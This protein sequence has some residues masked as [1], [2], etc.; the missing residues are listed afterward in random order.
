MSAPCVR[1]VARYRWESL[2]AEVLVA[3]L[4]SAA[5]V[6]ASAQTTVRMAKGAHPTF[7]LVTIKLSDPESHQQG[8][9]FHGRE[10]TATG[11]TVQNLMMFAY[12]VHGS[13]IA[14]EPAWVT[15]DRYDI[16]AVPDVPGEPDLKQIQEIY[17]RVWFRA[18]RGRRR[19]RVRWGCRE[20]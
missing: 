4:L 9:G 5:C 11:E 10:V 20:L 1:G 14:D 3:I 19:G 7:D 15:T 16:Q 6:L 2:K 13:Q 18:G 12:G 17:P 8:I